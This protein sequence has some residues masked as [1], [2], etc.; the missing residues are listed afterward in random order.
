M[1][2]KNPP[3]AQVP[4]TVT[5]L[6]TCNAACRSWSGVL[7]FHAHPSRAVVGGVAY[8]HWKLTAKFPAMLKRLRANRNEEAKTLRRLQR[9]MKPGQP[10]PLVAGPVSHA[11]RAKEIRAF[12]DRYREV[13]QFAAGTRR[14]DGLPVQH[15]PSGF[16]SQRERRDFEAFLYELSP[17]P[18]FVQTGGRKTK[19]TIAGQDI[20]AVLNDALPWHPTDGA[21]KLAVAPGLGVSV[22]TINRRL[23]KKSKP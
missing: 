11:R 6:S 7:E 14:S 21:A 23:P 20:E 12:N 18:F 3:P 1:P 19:S 5:G 16:E 9:A 10:M 8:P 17:Q 13:F 2:K 15:F 4:P 22:S